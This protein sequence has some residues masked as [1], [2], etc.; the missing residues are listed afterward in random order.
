MMVS[1]LQQT[2]QGVMVLLP[3][4]ALASLGLTADTEVT[5][6]VNAAQQQIV[7]TPA[8]QPAPEVDEAFAHQVAAFINE[9]RPALE[10]LAR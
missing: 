5:V 10:A 3:A 4:E 1:K 7:I 2:E 9:Y 6:S 8:H